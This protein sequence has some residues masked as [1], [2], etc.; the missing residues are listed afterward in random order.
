[1]NVK[2]LLIFILLTRR[3]QI[4]VKR[5]HT[6][7]RPVSPI[8][9]HHHHVLIPPYAPKLGRGRENC[10]RKEKRK[11]KKETPRRRFCLSPSLCLLFN[12]SKAHQN[13]MMTLQ[14]FHA[15]KKEKEKKYASQKTYD[16][17][18]YV[19]TSVPVRANQQKQQQQKK[20]TTTTTT[21]AVST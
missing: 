16:T 4:N 17:T 10:K 21:A 20:N 6:R 7:S 2:L 13:N 8:S 1:M 14:S 18:I 9:P 3:K 19:P 5:R 11:R 12:T 15:G